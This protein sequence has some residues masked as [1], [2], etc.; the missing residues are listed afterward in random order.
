VVSEPDMH[1]TSA[2]NLS[3]LTKDIEKEMGL[4][5]NYEITLNGLFQL[6]G[7]HAGITLT[8]SGATTKI[9]LIVRDGKSYPVNLKALASGVDTL[10][11]ENAFNFFNSGLKN[12][13]IVNA[14]DGGA[15]QVQLYTVDGKVIRQ[16][17]AVLSPYALNLTTAKSGIYMVRLT[18]SA[19][20]KSF[21]FIVQ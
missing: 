12:I 13:F 8:N 17:Q 16:E 2:T 4:T 1:R 21:K 11:T 20:S 9:A 5:A 6:D 18:N 3:G 19:V 7:D 14:T 10:F 15:F